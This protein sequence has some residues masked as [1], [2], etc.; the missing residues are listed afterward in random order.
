[1]RESE[2]AAGGRGHS[3]R[4][5]G[6]SERGRRPRNSAPSLPSQPHSNRLRAGPAPAAQLNH[7]PR[8]LKHWLH[9]RTTCPMIHQSRFFRD[10]YR[11]NHR[12]TTRRTPATAAAT[13]TT[14][15]TTI[16]AATE[17]GH[18]RIS[19]EPLRARQKTVQPKPRTGPDDPPR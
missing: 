18:D 16:T 8:M 1:M 19:D 17:P 2:V 15:T 10:R 6:N 3:F 4:R 9:P 7:G 12:P 14:T 11:D 13:G 5:S